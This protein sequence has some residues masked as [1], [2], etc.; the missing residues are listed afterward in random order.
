MANQA[1]RMRAQHGPPK[2]CR[3]PLIAQKQQ[4]LCMAVS[5]FQPLLALQHEIKYH[6]QCVEQLFPDDFTADIG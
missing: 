6:L 4:N 5:S 3:M 2:P 1:V